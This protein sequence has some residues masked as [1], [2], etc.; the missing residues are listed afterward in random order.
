MHV[1]DP[2]TIQELVN[3]VSARAKSNA[4]L[5]PYVPFL[6]QPALRR[7]SFNHDHNRHDDHGSVRVLPIPR[8][9]WLLFVLIDQCKKPQY[10]HKLCQER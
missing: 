3:E 7:G 1:M 9:N 10:H 4:T 6:R 8:V 5:E 2:Q